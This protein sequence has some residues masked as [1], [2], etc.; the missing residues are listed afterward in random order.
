MEQVALPAPLVLLPEHERPQREVGVDG[1]RPVGG[2][3]HPGPP[4]RARA[5]VAGP[6]GVDHGHARPPTREIQR[7]PAAERP[8]SHH[9]DVR[10]LPHGNDAF[11]K[12][13]GR[14]RGAGLEKRAP[15]DPAHGKLTRAPRASRSAR[16]INSATGWSGIR[17]ASRWNVITESRVATL[18]PITAG[19]SRMACSVWL[20]YATPPAGSYR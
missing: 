6:P 5:R 4:P 3:D 8:C 9:D 14:R 11:D 10:F 15:R 2:A 16:A 7:G 19:S 12:R 18:M 13:E 20:S 1:A 17:P